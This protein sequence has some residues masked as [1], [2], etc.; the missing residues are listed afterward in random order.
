[1]AKALVMDIKE[2]KAAYLNAK[3]DEE[4]FGADDAEDIFNGNV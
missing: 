3:S 2:A 4:E 1:L